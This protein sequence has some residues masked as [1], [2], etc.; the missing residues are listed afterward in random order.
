MKM[1]KRLLL[2]AAIMMVA[3]ASCGDYLDSNNE[4]EKPLPVEPENLPMFQFNESGIPYRYGLPTI[5]KNIQE[6]LKKEFIGYGWKWMQTNEIQEN[7][8]AVPTGYY[9]NLYGASPS[10]YY[11]ETNASV[12]RYFFS[13]AIGSYAFLQSGYTLDKETCTMTS[14]NNMVFM[15]WNILLRVW[16]IYKL[17]GRW[18]MSCVEPL[19]VRIAEDGQK[20]LVWGTSQYV[21]MT[22]KELREM[23]QRHTFDCSGIN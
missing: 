7:G 10:S 16:S 11:I 4:P 14:N 20:H 15:P 5:P 8:R 12:T 18:Y 13:D 22:D 21:R 23:Q 1:I 9:D 17:S 19:H 2:F 6:S 3:T